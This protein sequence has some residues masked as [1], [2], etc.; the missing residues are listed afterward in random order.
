MT[1]DRCG[2]VLAVGDFPFCPHE[3]TATAIIT[4]DV[5]GGFWAENGFETPRKFYSHS[6]HRAALAANGCEI[7]AKWAGP[8]DK[9]MSRWDAVGPDQL[10]KAIELVSRPA[11]QFVADDEKIPIE[12]T[13]LGTF[14]VQEVRE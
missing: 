6:E 7:R 5:P 10:K 3:R 2:T 12:T 1:C 9:I 13:M 8:H 4:D 11:R 14:R